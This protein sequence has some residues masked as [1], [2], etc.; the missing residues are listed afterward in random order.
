METSNN[1][2]FV[3]SINRSLYAVDALAVKQTFSLPAI[4]SID[5]APQHIAGV[6]NLRGNIIPIIDFDILMGRPA[7][8]KN[9][10]DAI[11][12]IQCQQSL[13][14]MIVNEVLDV[15]NISKEQIDPPPR[16][17]GKSY[18]NGCLI[19]GMARVGEQII[20]IIDYQLLVS[21]NFEAEEV[22][23]NN[24]LL[25]TVDTS[26]A[27]HLVLKKRAAELIRAVD[28]ETDSD[29]IQV[30]VVMLGQEYFGMDIRNVNEF[31]KIKNIIPLP[32]CPQHILGNMNL[33]GSILTIIDI[34]S[35]L[36]MYSET[37][38]HQ[39]KIV[40]SSTDDILVGVAVDDI[41]DIVQIS[42]GEVVP[43]PAATH[44]DI[45]RFSMGTVHYNQKAM[46]ILNLPEI[47]KNKELVVNER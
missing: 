37:F 28:T 29:S 22:S 10:S 45:M 26:E 18:S 17:E 8:Q 20:S 33:R 1:L 12:V 6:I 32:N 40:V 27:E 44:P 30:A 19:L 13:L 14:G 38:T 21:Q 41:D 39:A 11:L 4:R 47:L 31:T 35:T 16:F 5:D 23:D 9:L 25:M 24:Q 34:R 15:I 7:K 36:G 2:Y 42:P 43:L 46:T 3:F